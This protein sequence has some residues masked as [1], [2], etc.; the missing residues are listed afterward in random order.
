MSARQY[1]SYLECVA[2]LKEQQAT[3]SQPLIVRVGDAVSELKFLRAK[4]VFEYTMPIVE[5]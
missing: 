3:L 1:S 5:H 2:D 4:V